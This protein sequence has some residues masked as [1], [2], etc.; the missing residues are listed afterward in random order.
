MDNCNPSIYY[1][2]RQEAANCSTAAARLQYYTE[3]RERHN[4]F[5][6]GNTVASHQ[7]DTI[8]DRTAVSSAEAELYAMGQATIEAQ[9][10]R[11]VHC[12]VSTIKRES[13]LANIKHVG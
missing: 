1:P 13:A 9:H 3:E 11:Q 12:V 2:W 8:D 4:Y 6:L 5:L 10:I 7:Q